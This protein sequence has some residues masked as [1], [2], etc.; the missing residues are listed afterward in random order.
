MRSFHF[1]VFIF[2]YFMFTLSVS[3]Q[4]PASNPE[5]SN[6]YSL[7]RAIDLA[8]SKNE[9]LAAKKEIVNSI[10]FAQK[11]AGV[12]QNP[13]LA[14]SYY[15]KST[16][17]Q[18]GNSYVASVAQPFYF[19]GKI[20]LREEIVGHD[21]QIGRLGLERERL[22]IQ[23]QV[24]NLSYQYQTLKKILEHTERRV[25]RLQ[26]IQ[27]YIRN[28][29]RVAPQVR[30]EIKIIQSRLKIAQKDMALLKASAEGVW[31]KLNLYLNLKGKP[32]LQLPEISP[33]TSLDLLAL[34]SSVERNFSL[35][36]IRVMKMRTESEQKL[37]DKS[38]Y[39]DFA[40]TAFVQDE[41]SNANDR[42]YGIGGTFNLPLFDRQQHAS[43]SLGSKIAAQE[44]EAKYLE[45]W[46]KQELRAMH[47]LFESARANI[48]RYPIADISKEEKE[49]IYLDSEFR[50]GRVQV[51]TYLEAEA[52][53]YNNVMIA[54]E[55]QARFVELYS[56]LLFLTGQKDFTLGGEDAP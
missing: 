38:I 27:I 12:W 32:N 43:S 4:E 40:V 47:A 22:F 8:L 35:K 18:Y 53:A 1:H 15:R 26:T 25:Q 52:A 6:V 20:S 31:V 55:N 23:Y 51:V 45:K 5:S 7:R 14:F 49:F 17:G 34:E 9:N 3:T 11:H 37:A 41:Y 19:P 44:Q 21:L 33:G 2:S 28:R 42:F 46:L 50:K 16:E 36:E 13:S 56:D 10:Q 24:V 30:A 54:W 39:P 48:E 29:P